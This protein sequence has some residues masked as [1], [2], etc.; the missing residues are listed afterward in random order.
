MTPWGARLD[1]ITTALVR[2][3]G[4]APVEAMLEEEA[5]R[6]GAPRPRAGVLQALDVARLDWCIFDAETAAGQGG[7]LNEYRDVW[8][9]L[10]VEHDWLRLAMASH[11]SVFDLDDA[12]QGVDLFS[13]APVVF[14]LPASLSSGVTRGLWE[15]RVVPGAR[16]LHV[17]RPPRPVPVEVRAWADAARRP[18]W[19]CVRPAPMERW[20]R[21]HRSWIAGGGRG[22]IAPLLG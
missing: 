6:F 13:G 19:R 17:A 3:I 2:T 4:R 1:T 21:A 22:P 5:R 16:T 9:R 12:G 10:P 15:M 18:G 7:I 11:V 8:A 20:L 14:R